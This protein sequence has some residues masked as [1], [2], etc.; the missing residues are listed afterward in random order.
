MSM[1]LEQTSRYISE[2]LMYLTTSFPNMKVVVL[3]HNGKNDIGMISNSLDTLT[4][5]EILSRGMA[6]CFD[7][8]PKGVF[9]TTCQSYV[10]V[11][12]PLV[13]SVNGADGL[14]CFWDT[15]I[16]KAAMLS[17]LDDCSLAM[18]II[19]EH[20]VRVISAGYNGF[21]DLSDNAPRVLH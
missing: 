4:T 12:K 15:K 3:V 13:E 8:M 16:R 19:C 9:N 17:T 21:Y 2:N 6:S 5:Y 20:L 1:T 14:I 11:I 7:P 10:S 18:A